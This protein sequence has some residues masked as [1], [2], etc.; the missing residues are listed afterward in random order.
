MYSPI[1]NGVAPLLFM[2]FISAPID[3]INLKKKI[4]QNYFAFCIYIPT[5]LLQN[6]IIAFI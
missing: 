3:N 2:A 4:Q 1:C 6:W 5:D